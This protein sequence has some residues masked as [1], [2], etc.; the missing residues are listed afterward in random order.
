MRKKSILILC[1]CILLTIA[2]C[3]AV[4]FL[5]EQ[6]GRAGQTPE[7][8][9]A[10]AESDETNASD[11]TIWDRANPQPET[12]EGTPQTETT[13]RT[14]EATNA[15]SEEGKT[16]DNNVPT[17]QLTP[18]TTY[19]RALAADMIVAISLLYSDFT[20]QN[21][22]L[23]AEHEIAEKKS[24]EGVYVLFESAGTSY[25]VHSQPL[26][27]ER[28]APG[29]VDLSTG[30]LGYATFDITSAEEFENQGYLRVEIGELETLISQSL[31]VT[32][33]EH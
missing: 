11:A 27:G 31:L 16:P 24:S 22:Y 28:T 13:E 17:F 14:P 26:Q 29:T 12:A 3:A 2:A 15:T 20:I 21:V 10:T 9:T 6:S 33:Y 25:C 7:N 8:S 1:F 18:D 4:V 23:T 32:V 5:P 30:A 19:E